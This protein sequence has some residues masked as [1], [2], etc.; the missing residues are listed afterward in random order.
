MG[1][2]S[3]SRVPV[4]AQGRPRV[5]IIGCRAAHH[6][7]SDYLLDHSFTCFSP[8]PPPRP[9]CR[10]PR[11]AL[12]RSREGGPGGEG[13]HRGRSP[14]VN[15][16]F[17]MPFLSQRPLHRFTRRAGLPRTNANTQGARGPAAR[18]RPSRKRE[19]SASARCA[20]AR[21]G[22]GATLNS[23]S[24]GEFIWESRSER[25]MFVRNVRKNG[26]EG[27]RAES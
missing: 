22:Q 15:A 2:G 4:P 20:W 5:G 16:G 18:D 8:T 10:F 12:T 13:A 11:S 7:G 17:S 25:G 14:H 1:R 27:E 9:S 23:G 24:S 6:F 21:W 19:R 3:K 26:H